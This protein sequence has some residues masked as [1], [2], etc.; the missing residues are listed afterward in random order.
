[1]IKFLVL[2][3]LAASPAAAQ[4][5]TLNPARLVQIRGPIAENAIPAAQQI[6]KLADGSGQS[7]DFFIDSPGG[8]VIVGG[9]VLNA[10][11]AAKQRGHKIRCAVGNMAASMA[12]QILIH[13]DE[14]AAMKYS[15]LLFHPMKA[16][17][18]PVSAERAQY[19]YERLTAM[20]KPFIRDLIRAL[21]INLNTF[22]YHYRNETLW[23]A[24][25]FG[26]LSPGFI[27]IVN[28]IKGVDNI[29]GEE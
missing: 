21:K 16:S 25:E 12:F 14:R 11:Q 13:C 18:G 2:L 9:I 17:G 26:Q 29:F 27:R 19:L 23:M 20:E 1:M 15:Y 6:N 22:V 8:N 5:I 24:T 28:D 7:I 4:T 3:M 10:I